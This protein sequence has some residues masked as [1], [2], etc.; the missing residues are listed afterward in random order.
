MFLSLALLRNK[1]PGSQWIGKYRRPRKVT[2]GM[3]TRMIRRLEIEAE[4]QYW[5]SCSYLTA[6]E[7]YK[8]NTE[9]RQAQWEA[10]RSRIVSNF[11]PHKYLGDRLNHLNVSKK[12]TAT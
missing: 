8:H 11:P 7:E 3:K 5:L 10:L 9:R 12:W 4:N 1:I 6:K 2:L